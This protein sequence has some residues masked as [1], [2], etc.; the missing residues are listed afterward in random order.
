M[1]K[2]NA[3]SNLEAFL[4]ILLAIL[5]YLY[6]RQ[7]GGAAIEKES[8]K[9][10]AHSAYAQLNKIAPNSMGREGFAGEFS[11]ESD[12]VEYI[13]NSLKMLKYCNNAKNDGC[14][15]N[16]WLWNDADKAGTQLRTLQ[17]V[18]VDFVSKDCAYSANI[19]NTCA[20][21]YVDTNGANKPNEV[22]KDI[23]LFYMTRQGF[24]PAG[25]QFDTVTKASDCDIK[26]NRY[27]WGCTAQLLGLK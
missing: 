26:N 4:V 23:L 3:L 21:V 6:T 13:G 11:N 25:T 7:I 27:N 1:K 17:F 18:L 5:I 22:G 8:Y 12:I 14:W 10:T 9:T 2:L 19:P 20:F 24:I 15:S 16:T